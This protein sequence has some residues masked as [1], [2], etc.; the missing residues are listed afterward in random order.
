MSKEEQKKQAPKEGAP[1]EHAAKEGK[2]G[3]QASGKKP[4]GSG[5]KHVSEAVEAEAAAGPKAPPRL[6]VMFQDQVRKAVSD[7][8]GISNPMEMP[9]LEKIVLNV[10][11][12]RHLEGSKLP[13][14]V[15]TQVLE[16]LVKVTGQK[17]VVV[18]AKKSVSNFK[19]REGFESSAMV[20]IR[21]E[22]MWHF[23][24]R[25]INLATP[26]IKDFRGLPDKAFDR[27]G[28]YAMG[29]TEQGVFPEIN[30]AEAQFTHGMNINFCFS[31]STP[32]RSRF[33][34]EQ[35]GMPFRKPDQK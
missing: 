6:R 23:L 11:M 20:T 27:Q 3:G 7:K 14:H 8:F 29:L 12:G 31:N 35:L 5:K 1:K 28:N 16:T 21:R 26:R 24:D 13:P 2:K 15:K 30:M 22:R 10:N 25:L 17:P 9:K 32:K 19:L 4:A 34:L 18:K 33:V